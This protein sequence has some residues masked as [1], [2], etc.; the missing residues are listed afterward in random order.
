MWISVVHYIMFVVLGFIVCWHGQ[1]YHTFFL[2]DMTRV[3]YHFVR[4]N[5]PEKFASTLVNF[6]GKV[7]FFFND[8]HAYRPMN[9][10]L[11]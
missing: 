4:G 7:S 3:S 11:F 5:S 8:L 10:F 9:S 1:Y 2:Q 6:M